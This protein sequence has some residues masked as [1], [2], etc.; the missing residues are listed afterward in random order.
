[1]PPRKRLSRPKIDMSILKDAIVDG[2]VTVP[3]GTRLY[4]E[5][6]VTGGKIEIHAGILRDVDVDEGLVEVWDET[7]EQF[8]AFSLYQKLPVVKVA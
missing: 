1:M 8:Y 2:A 4:F 5:R 7:I 6:T 3:V